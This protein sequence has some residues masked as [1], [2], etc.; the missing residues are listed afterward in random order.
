M[1]Q[2]A[3]ATSSRLARRKTRY[4]CGSAVWSMI[5]TAS[6]FASGQIVLVGVPST[7]MAAILA[8]RQSLPKDVGG[9][10]RSPQTQ[11][12]SVLLFSARLM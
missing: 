3:C 5:S 2:I 8:V 11:R 1:L 7:L 4:A 12:C 10:Q 6:A 9:D